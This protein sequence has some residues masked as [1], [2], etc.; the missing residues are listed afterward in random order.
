MNILVVHNSLMDSKSVSGVLKH[1]AGMA[2]E[3]IAAGHPTDFLVARAGFP[4]FQSL[5]PEAGLVSS[6]NVFDATRYLAKTWRYFPAYGWRC[7]TAHFTRL[8]RRYD[9]VYASGQ[10]IVDLYCARVIAR[11]QGVPW[12]AKIQ[13]VLHSQPKRQGFI[14]GLFLNSETLAARWMNRHAAQVMCLSGV[15]AEDYRQLEESLGLKPTE[16]K[17]VGCGIDVQALQAVPAEEKRFDVVFLGRM[18][19]Q[20]GVFELPEVWRQVLA[21][22]PDAKMVVI[23]EGPH[24]QKMEALFR[25][26]GIAG[27]VTCT[28]G[29]EEA[30]KNKLLAQ[31]RVGLSLS[32]EEGWGLSVTEFLALGLPVVAYDLPV[33]RQI[34]PQQLASVNPG[35]RAAAAKELLA[36]LQDEPRRLASGSQG[37]AFA[38]RYDYRQI[39]R[40]ELRVL[41]SA[42]A[43]GRRAA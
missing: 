20:K 10:F 34:F 36:L 24:R 6:D 31:S 1:Y 7:L 23:G 4:Q 29:I 11:R 15:V 8:P 30:A 16:T 21:G 18:H 5:C 33:F 13:H 14:N 38:L 12:V 27:S 26:L 35:D 3:W 2:N 40:E 37:R 43:A 17:T 22:K 32:Y 28:G 19:E 9:V 42:A 41:H 25:E 39:A